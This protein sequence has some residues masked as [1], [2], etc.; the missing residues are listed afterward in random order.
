MLDQLNDG[1]VVVTVPVG[2]I[3]MPLDVVLFDPADVTL[4]VAVAVGPLSPET[5]ALDDDCTMKLPV[6]VEFAVGV[7]F[8]PALACASVRNSP[9]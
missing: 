5:A 4:M 9:L 7:N 8:N 6:A 1:F 3:K 2:A